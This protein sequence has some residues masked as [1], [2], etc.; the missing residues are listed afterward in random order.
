MIVVAMILVLEIV[1]ELLLLF[2]SSITAVIHFR[3]Y[4]DPLL[5]CK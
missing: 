5:P 1:L 3:P 4:F 2:I